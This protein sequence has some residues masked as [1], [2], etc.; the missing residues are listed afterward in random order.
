MNRYRTGGITVFDADR[1]SDILQVI[2]F[3]GR[4]GM[5]AVIGGGAEAW[6]VAD[7]LAEAG[8]PVLIDPGMGRSNMIRCLREVDPDG[9]VRATPFH[10]AGQDAEPGRLFVARSAEQLAGELAIAEQRAAGAARR[11]DA[12]R[13]DAVAAQLICENWL[14]EQRG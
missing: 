3:A 5:K 2:E 11:K 6:M 12:S 13:L 8:V 10:D 1:A 14:R 9:F 7:R 4:H